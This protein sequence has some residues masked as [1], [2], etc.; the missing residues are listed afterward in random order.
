MTNETGKKFECEYE[1]S[2]RRYADLLASYRSA[3]LTGTRDAGEIYDLH[4][5]DSLYS[6]EL[7][8]QAGE[9]IDVG[10]GGGLPGMVW[11]IC[12]PDLEVTLLDSMRKKCRAMTEIAAAL[13]L[14]NVSVTW[15]RCEE[16]SAAARERYAL[17]SA[18]ALAHVGI[19]AEYLS[20]LVARGGKAMAFKGPKGLKEL[21]E[22]GNKWSI[23]GLSNPQ[24]L[25]YGDDRNFN[26]NFVIWE[27]ISPT[28]PSYPRKTGAASAVGWWVS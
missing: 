13:S 6:I 9:I 2:L 21:E 5:R 1:K 18:R 23:I 26:Y 25:P 3:R 12:R 28:P 22:V 14:K 4:I 16:F 11:A 20:P 7:L 15:A 24:I 8:P 17:A 10:S 27:K 19:V